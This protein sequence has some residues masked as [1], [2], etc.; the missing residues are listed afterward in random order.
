MIRIK[1]IGYAYDPK[2]KSLMDAILEA[3]EIHSKKVGKKATHVSLPKIATAEDV[4]MTKKGLGL[5]VS[6]IDNG[7]SMVIVGLPYEMKDAT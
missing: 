3:Y 5:E 1:G 4:R 6:G 2:K 7:A